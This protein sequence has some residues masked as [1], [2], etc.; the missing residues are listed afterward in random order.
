MFLNCPSFSNLAASTPRSLDVLGRRMY[1]KL[2]DAWVS[3]RAMISASHQSMIRGH[4]TYK[5]KKILPLW[6]LLPDTL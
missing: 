1:R 3:A 6:A 2:L 5:K 4:L